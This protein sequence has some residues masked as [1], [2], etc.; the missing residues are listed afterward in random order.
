VLGL[1]GGIYELTAS[2][3]L[4]C[5]LA[6]A[7]NLLADIETHPINASQF[8]TCSFLVLAIQN[9]LGREEFLLQAGRLGRI[10]HQLFRRKRM[11][12][13]YPRLCCQCNV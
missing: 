8:E 10:W 13:K 2:H 4:C 3:Q 1:E 5:R 11:H 7:E 9:G 6:C 12:S